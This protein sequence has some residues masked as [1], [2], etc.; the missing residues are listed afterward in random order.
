VVQGGAGCSYATDVSKRTFLPDG[1]SGA[2]SV[3]G[4]AG[5][6]WN[7]ASNVPWITI[8]SGQ[9]GSGSG[10]VTFNVAANTSAASRIGDIF[11][12]GKTITVYQGGV[13]CSYSITPNRVTVGPSGGETSPAIEV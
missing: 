10:T 12:A 9:T 1:G 8:A 5:C 7:S 13:G 4:G 3:T 2:V 6:D 11:V